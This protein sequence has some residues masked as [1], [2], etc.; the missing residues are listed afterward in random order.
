MMAFSTELIANFLPG[1]FAFVM[2]TGIVS[3]AA[4]GLRLDAVALPLFL[5]NLVAFPLLWGITVARLILFP[6]Q[7]LADLTDHRTGATFLTKVA[8]TSVVGNQIAALAGYL[9]SAA[10]L[11]LAA[12]LLWLVLIYTFF[13][14]MTLKASKPEL[15][16]SLSGAWLLV[17]VATQSLC[18]LGTVVAGV[19]PSPSL[20]IFASL[21]A[22]LLGGMFYIVLISL[23][24]YRWLFLPMGAEMLTPPY[25]INMGAVAITTLAGAHLML[26]ANSDPTLVELAPVLHA[27]T[28]LFWATA[29]WWIPL[30]II[31]T[32][33]RHGIE[34]VPLTYDL[35]Y[36][37][38]VFPLGMYTMAT[39]AYANAA[40]LGFLHEISHAFIWIALTAWAVTAVGLLRTIVS[41]LRHVGTGGSETV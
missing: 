32:V 12:V 38:M 2:A 14:A 36:W 33:W 18:V 15:R 13:A 41:S 21:S 34:R 17:V 30:L 10:A 16:D 1:S 37:S 25:W 3:L 9:G 31:V 4:H 27:F 20:V 24:L 28:L 6:R 35:Q 11:W 26:F 22:F 40:R 8:A 39:E 29:T 19:L 7:L 23:I 5:V